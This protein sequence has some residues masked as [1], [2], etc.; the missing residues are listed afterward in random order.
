MGSRVRGDE[1]YAQVGGP[2]DSP[3][4]DFIDYPTNENNSTTLCCDITVDQDF[5]SVKGSYVVSPVDP[6]TG[7]D[8]DPDNGHIITE[9]N[10]DAPS[11]GGYFAFGT[12]NKIV[13]PGRVPNNG[14]IDGNT[15]DV[16]IP[17][18]ETEVPPSRIIRFEVNQ[19]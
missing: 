17:V 4:L 14:S 19:S 6:I 5:S 3:Q 1:G 2:S 10:T 18:T 7:E 15:G 12:E 9:W 13:V 11:H 8:Q 16:M